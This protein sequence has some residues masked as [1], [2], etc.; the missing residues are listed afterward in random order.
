MRPVVKVVGT[1]LVVAGLAAL[2]LVLRLTTSR[3]KS[4]YPPVAAG[5]RGRAYPSG[6]CGNLPETVGVTTRACSDEADVVFDVRAVATLRIETPSDV[7]AGDRLELR[8]EA[9]DAGGVKLVLGDQA[10]L[11]WTFSGALAARPRPSCGDILPIC[12]EEDHGYANAIS[13][14][15]GDVEVTFGE[16]RAHT[17]IQVGPRRGTE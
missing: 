14:G 2:A 13:Q 4:M 16:L 3:V 10:P 12:P 8:A 17:T 11:H 15:S 1:S 5:A 9:F 6:Y 7:R